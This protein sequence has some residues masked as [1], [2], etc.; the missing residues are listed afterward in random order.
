M[1]NRRQENEKLDQILELAIEAS[2]EAQGK[3]HN[4]SLK[5]SLAHLKDNITKA[6]QTTVAKTIDAARAV[7]GHI[8][9]KPWIYIA[10]AAIGGLAIGFF[11]RRPKR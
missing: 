8:H 6:K 10:G 7:H 3:H 1:N 5:H 4:G 9:N 11:C 2:G